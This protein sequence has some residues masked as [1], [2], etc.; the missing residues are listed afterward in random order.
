MKIEIPTDLS[1]SAKAEIQA[2]I[3]REAYVS[4]KMPA[5]LPAKGETDGK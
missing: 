3:D 1:K 4:G 5:L 2:I